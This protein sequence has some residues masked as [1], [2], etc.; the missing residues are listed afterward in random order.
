MLI[1]EKRI[2]ATGFSMG[3]GKTWDLYQEYP[4]SFAGFMPCSALFPI[5]ENPYGLSLGDAI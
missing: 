3:S 1:D 5:K 4:G 2:Y